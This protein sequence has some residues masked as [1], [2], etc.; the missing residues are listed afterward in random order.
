MGN[1]AQGDQIRARAV[2]HWRVGGHH[3]LRR[4][5]IATY[6]ELVGG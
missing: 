5:G 3:F 1:G 4:G 6:E 2:A